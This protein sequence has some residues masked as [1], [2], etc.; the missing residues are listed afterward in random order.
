MTA[1][2]LEIESKTDKLVELTAGLVAAYIS[3]NAVPLAD[4]P[5]LI[6]DVHAGACHIN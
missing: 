5:A 1:Q 3:N 2:D 6:D 4:L